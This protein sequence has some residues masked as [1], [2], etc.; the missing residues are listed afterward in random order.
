MINKSVN[1]LNESDL[2][3]LIGKPETRQLEY[4]RDLPK[5]DYDGVKEFL[6]DVSAMANTSGGDLIYGISEGKDADGNTVAVSVEGISGEDAN[7]VK[8]GLKDLIRHNIK[9]PL[10]AFDIQDVLLANANWAYIVRVH[11][12]W[13]GPHVVDYKKHWRFYYRTTNSVEMMDLTQ[14]RQAMIL[15]DSLGQR[16]NEFRLHRLTAIGSDPRFRG[17]GKIVMHLQPLES[18]QPAQQANLMSARLN[19]PLLAGISLDQHNPSIRLNFDGIL[20]SHFLNQKTSYVQV[21]RSG[22]VEAADAVLL[23]LKSEDQRYVPAL[24]FEKA[25]IGAIV[26]YLALINNLEVRSPVLLHLSLLDVK[27]YLLSVRDSGGFAHHY[28][29]PSPFDLDDLL[30]PEIMISDADLALYRNLS[31]N[32]RNRC[33]SASDRASMLVRPLFDTIYNAANLEK[34][35]FYNAEGIWT[36]E[37]N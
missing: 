21:F 17:D 20:A 28:Y 6:K 1:E 15:S 24:D 5:N 4:K 16:L 3:N 2:L 34:S 12:S 10:F 36:R 33:S 25:I 11:R 31:L 30:F 23:R 37:F 19:G 27:G 7:A 13:N 14:L 22:A 9:P 26:R 32:D 35:P 8:L 18:L 29:Q